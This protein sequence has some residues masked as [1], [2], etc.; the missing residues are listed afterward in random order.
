MAKC[1]QKNLYFISIVWTRFFWKVLFEYVHKY[2]FS[3]FLKYSIKTVIE[4]SQDILLEIVIKVRHC[5]NDF[6]QPTFL[7][8]NE[9]TISTLLLWNLRSTCF[10]SFFLEEIEGTKKTFWNKLT[11]INFLFYVLMLWMLQSTFFT[12]YSTVADRLV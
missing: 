3:H 7:P 10:R 6:F 5:R 2:L 12:L 8:K 9:L 1:R 11:F 4:L